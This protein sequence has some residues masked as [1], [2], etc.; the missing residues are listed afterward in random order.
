MKTSIVF[1]MFLSLFAAATDL[2]IERADHYASV[3]NFD[4]A[5]IHYEYVLTNKDFAKQNPEKWFEAFKKMFVISIQVKRNT[6]LAVE[7]VS[8]LR[9]ESAVPSK[10]KKHS[11]TWKQ[12]LKEW[13]T[14][15]QIT[16]T[17]THSFEMA[18]ELIAKAGYLESIQGKSAGLVNLL[19]SSLILQDYLEQ[20]VDTQNYAEALYL[21]GV[22]AKELNTISKS[23]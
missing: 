6:N 20:P 12:M 22:V 11:G 9:D 18:K 3:Q 8:R 14:D 15:K 21:S 23:F 7:L 13:E 10:Y 16:H 19:R 5:I 4:Q 2:N 1:T 17:K